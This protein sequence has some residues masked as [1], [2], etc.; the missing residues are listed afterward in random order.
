M[1]RLVLLGALGRMG[2]EVRRLA[3]ESGEA[4]IA[5]G[6]DLAE[7]EGGQGFPVAKTIAGADA[8]ADA[9]IS[10][11]P[12]TADGETSALLDFCAASGMPAAIATSGLCAGMLAKMAEA[13]K[14]AA[15]L[16]SPNFSFGMNIVD[17]LLPGLA[18]TLFGAGFD[19]EISERH[20]RRKIDS[21]SGTAMAFAETARAALGDGV[22]IAHDRSHK[23][24]PRKRREI[25]VVAQR[26]GGV[27]GE[28]SILFAAEDEVIEISHR[29]L[30]RGVFAKGALMAAKFLVGKPPGMYGMRDLAGIR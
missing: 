10:F 27:F 17:G 16:H 3:K 29:A 28:H 15:L 20:H 7:P 14:F 9:A 30:G 18:K 6:V 12:P 4:E 13:S 23:K 22:G 24:E 5:L 25:G 21:P 19:I 11:L 26:G 8:R 2:S 1:I